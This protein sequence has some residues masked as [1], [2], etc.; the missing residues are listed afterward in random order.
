M[1]TRRALGHAGIVVFCDEGPFA[2][3]GER[4][5]TTSVGLACDH[6]AAIRC[7]ELKGILAELADEAA[8]RLLFD[9]MS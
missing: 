1:T 8:V 5:S 9:V 7:G 2:S 6:V 3:W 4:F